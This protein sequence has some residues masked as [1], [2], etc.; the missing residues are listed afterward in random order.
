MYQ[1]SL[2]CVADWALIG[3]GHWYPASV[4]TSC[5][6]CGRLV[7][8]RLENVYTDTSRSTVVGSA[9]CPACT[10][11]SHFWAVEPSS[12]PSPE[13]SCN[14]LYIYP[15]P[16]A[17]RESAVPAGT[18]PVP[19]LERVYR[20]AIQAFNAGLWDACATSCRKTLEGIVHTQLP[21]AKGRLFDN[22]REMFSKPELLKPFVHLADTLRKGGNLGA[23]FDSDMEPD[24]EV[25]TGMLDLLDFF[26][27]YLFLL[28]KKSKELEGR[29][30][31]FGDK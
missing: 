23:H 15:H 25:V 16:S 6:R 18:L 4:D 19:A 29:L 22:L 2:A 12:S 10:K 9:R 14:G 26:M 21:D 3:S 27:E 31:K 30:S 8:F 28:P 20:S 7:N 5:P 24:R 11:L 17:V 1:L 13:R